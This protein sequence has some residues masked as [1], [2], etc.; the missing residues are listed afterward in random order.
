MC[1]T[2]MFLYS[3][4]YF[5]MFKE[6]VYYNSLHPCTQKSS[7]D[8]SNFD[9]DF[10]FQ[11]AQLTPTDKQ[12]ILSIDQSNFLGFSYTNEQLALKK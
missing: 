9:D 7:A 3:I 10:T 6:S 12:L 5:L 8:A 11:P 4:I 2:T 1:P